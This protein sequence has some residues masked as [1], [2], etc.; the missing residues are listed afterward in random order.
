[1]RKNKISLFGVVSFVLFLLSLGM[2]IISRRSVGAADYLNE[3]ISSPFRRFMASFGDIFPF[4]LFELLVILSPILAALLIWRF[5]VVFRRG[6]GRARLVSNVLA[7]AL[8][9]YSGNA[10]AL[11]ISYN[12]TS[13]DEYMKLPDVTVNEEGLKDA[14]TE[15][16]LEVNALSEKIEFSDGES[17]SGYSLDELSEKI[18]ESYSEISEKY[19]CLA[20]FDSRAKGVDAL[21]FMSYLSLT[22]I[23]TYYSGESN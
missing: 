14:M 16:C 11:G 1:M 3:H 18:C 2:L 10:L 9:L 4:S 6:Y 5:V 20:S 8:L 17:H 13:V 19:G 21:H 15:L 12:T 7:I 23:Y 22:G